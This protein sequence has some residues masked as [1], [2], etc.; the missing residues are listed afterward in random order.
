MLTATPRIALFF[1]LGLLF[2]GPAGSVRSASAL[3]PPRLQARV[4]D[5]A[6]LLSPE[7]A[8]TLEAKLEAHEKKTG[9]QIVVLTLPSLEGESLEDFSVRVGREWGLGQEK[10]NNGVLLL[11]AAKERAVRI[12]VG[13][14]LE[15]ALTDAES[16]MIIRNVI[17]PAFQEGDF[18]RG[19]D[20]AIDSIQ[21]AIV[22]EFKAEPSPRRESPSPGHFNEIFSTGLILLILFSSFLSA[23]PVY[24]SGIVGA[25]IGGAVGAWMAGKILLPTAVG[26]FLGMLLSRLFRSSGGGRRGGWGGGFY[27]GG[28]WSAGSGF[29][30]GGSGGGFSGGGGS[31]GGGG[32]SG[33]W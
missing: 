5:Y 10:R 14:G 29:G 19:I 9:N 4:N 18:Y 1:L 12:E 25:I 20:Q 24:V 2:I 32:A 28:G 7:Q 8:R 30:G 27:R 33:R 23:L 17:V 13:Y 22:G 6:K 15:G 26:F 11:I 3:Q 31:F 21:A 16:S